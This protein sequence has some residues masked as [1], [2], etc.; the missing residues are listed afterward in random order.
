MHARG[1]SEECI[2]AAGKKHV[3]EGVT[4]TM[5]GGAGIALPRSMPF[6]E[7]GT[8]TESA[9]E[10]ANKTSTSTEEATANDGK[11]ANIPDYATVTAAPFA[12]VEALVTSTTGHLGV[13]TSSGL[14][15]RYG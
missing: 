11:M 6:S 14:G 4:P 5:V 12:S 15:A 8:A 1:E 3:A 10:S 13:F 2:E 7:T 9:T